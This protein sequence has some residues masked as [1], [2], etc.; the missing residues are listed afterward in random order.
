[1]NSKPVEALPEVAADLI[2]AARHYQSW[3]SD[4]QEHLLQKYEETVSWIA[5][6]PDLFPRK[7]GAVQRVVLK[8]SYYVVYFIQEPTRSVVLA[9]LD[10]RDDPTR[11]V[12]LLGQ[13][14]RAR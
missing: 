11:R 14:R 8:Q 3:R 5:W 6:N 2:A 7:F 9:V 12:R 1:V 13:R 10:G 4:G